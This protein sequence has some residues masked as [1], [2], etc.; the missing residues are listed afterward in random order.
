MPQVSVNG[1]LW[2][3]E[4]DLLQSG[5]DDQVYA[6]ALDDAGQTAVTFGDGL[7]GARPP[8]GRDNIHARYRQGLG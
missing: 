4:P 7:N 8:T 5:A 3:E 1:V 2:A 6:T